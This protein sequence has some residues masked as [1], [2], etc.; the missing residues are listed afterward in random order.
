MCSVI[1]I[2]YLAGGKEYDVFFIFILP[3][4]APLPAYYW[5]RVV[6]ICARRDF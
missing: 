6:I 3:A 4:I 2:S 1:R 5:H